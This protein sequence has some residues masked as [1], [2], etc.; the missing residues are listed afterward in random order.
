MQ[1]LAFECALVLYG[2]G[3]GKDD[4]QIDS[5]LLLRILG[6]RQA[7]THFRIPAARPIAPIPV[8]ALAG[9]DDG[10]DGNV[11]ETFRRL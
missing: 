3:S 11:V 10:E 9:P 4:S 7:A 1:R 8:A 5:E 6:V 2:R